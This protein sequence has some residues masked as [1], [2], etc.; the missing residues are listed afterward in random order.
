MVISDLQILTIGPL[1]RGSKNNEF[2]RV[3]T[4][5]TFYLIKSLV[6]PY[7]IETSPTFM[8]IRNVA[9]RRVRIEFAADPESK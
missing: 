8:I 7:I 5:K 4:Q 2:G 1:L 9:D 3:A 6:R